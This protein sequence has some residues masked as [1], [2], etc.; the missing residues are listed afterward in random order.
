LSI[1]ASGLPDRVMWNPG[2]NPGIGDVPPGGEA[3]FVCVE[4]AARAPGRLD[5]GQRW[6]ATATLTAG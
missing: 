4:P 5:A 1:E 2:P 3:E 6:S